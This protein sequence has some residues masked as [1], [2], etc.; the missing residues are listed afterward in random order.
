MIQKAE[1]N[2]AEIIS[3]V[4]RKT[5]FEAHEL[6]SPKEELDTYLNQKF[7]I[8]EVMKE[9]SD[10]TNVFHLCFENDELAGYS[11]IVYNC[12]APQIP[13]ITDACKLERLYLLQ[14]FYGKNLGLKLFNFNKTLCLQNNQSGMWLTVWTENERAIRFYEKLGFKTIGE[15]MF[16]VGN[17][18]NPNFVMWLEL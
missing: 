9:L 10:S 11:K 5:F 4:G 7:N 13:Y 1:I 3:T 14:N 12:P 6:S 8:E 18:Y 17:I 15:I 2:D 16:K